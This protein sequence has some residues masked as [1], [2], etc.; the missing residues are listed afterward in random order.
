MSEKTKR[1][2]WVDLLRGLA[3]LSMPFYHITYNLYAMGFTEIAYNKAPFW[4]VWQVTGLSSFILVS[5]MAFVLSTR[6]QINWP[7]LLRRGAK[8][9]LLA[10]AITTVTYFVMPEKFVRFGVLH[11]FALTVLLAPLF[12]PL[13]VFNIL[14]GASIVVFFNWMGK[15]GLFP[16]PWLYITG[17]MSDRP[18]SMDYVPL[19]P[20]FGVFLI[21]I[22]AGNLLNVEKL[23]NLPPAWTK[24]VIWLGQHSLSFYFIHQALLFGLFTLIKILFFST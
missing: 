16:D 11:F 24:P 22:G 14:I 5:G 17:L 7:R 13:G 23:R 4:K 6:N 3:C 8:L 2:W 9:I 21:G 15:A 12:R 19:I 10:V 20:W 1:V 18:R